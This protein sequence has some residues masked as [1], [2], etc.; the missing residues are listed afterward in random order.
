MYQNFLV[1]AHRQVLCAWQR[2]A[3][4]GELLDSG[5]RSLHSGSQIL[6]CHVA[7]LVEDPPGVVGGLVL[8]QM[9]VGGSEIWA[10]PPVR[11]EARIH[12]HSWPG[13]VTAV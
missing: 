10:L 8:Q 5:H 12:S 2:E 3:R 7:V 1:T 6:L 4:E 11:C 13:L 9:K